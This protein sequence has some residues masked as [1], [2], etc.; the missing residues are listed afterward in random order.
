LIKPHILKSGRIGDLLDVMF[1]ASDEFQIYGLLSFHFT[2]N[3][4]EELFD[5][6]RGIVEDYSK[7]IENVCSGPVLAVVI[8]PATTRDPYAALDFVTSFR[9]F[10]GP[11]N[12]QVARVLRP[13]SLRGSFG[14]NKLD[15]VLHCTD[16]PEDGEMEV[17]Y[18]FETIAKIK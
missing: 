7:L 16:L 3:L 18:I 15:N 17:R 9:E 11:Y 6:Y 13:K 10:S 5:A 1:Q 2:L 12:P 14:Q 4:A 8:T